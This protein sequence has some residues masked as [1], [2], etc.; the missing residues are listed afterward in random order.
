MYSTKYRSSKYNIK[1]IWSLGYILGQR[2]EAICTKNK[3]YCQ[4]KGCFHAWYDNEE[5]HT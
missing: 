5:G 1:R 2:K 3:P 4:Y